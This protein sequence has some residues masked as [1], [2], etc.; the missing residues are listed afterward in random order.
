MSGTTQEET[1]HRHDGDELFYLLKQQRKKKKIKAEKVGEEKLR[2]ADFLFE[3][4][5]YT[6]ASSL[7]SRP[8]KASLPSPEK[9][10]MHLSQWLKWG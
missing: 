7:P 1:R 5:K 4:D 6:L 9:L 2:G 8:P 10:N 3:A